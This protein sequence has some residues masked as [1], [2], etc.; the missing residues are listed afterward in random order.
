V[1]TLVLTPAVSV[2]REGSAGA[3]RASSAAIRRPIVSA[4]AASVSGASR[5][6]SSPPILAATSSTRSTL[7]PDCGQNLVADLVTMCVVDRLEMINVQQQE[8]D[9]RAVTA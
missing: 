8:G 9:R 2:H 4:P 1:L 5:T 7:R 6:N 3:R